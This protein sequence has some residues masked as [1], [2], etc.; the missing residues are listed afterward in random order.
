MVSKVSIS[1]ITSKVSISDITVVVY[2]IARCGQQG[3]YL[4]YYCRCVSD[5]KVWLAQC[6]PL[7]LL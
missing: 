5:S 6:L 4:C 1:D 2:Q 3:T 7:L